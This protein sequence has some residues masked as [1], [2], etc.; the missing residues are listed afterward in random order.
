M[1]LRCMQISVSLS[2]HYIIN[3]EI[4]EI[5]PLKISLDSRYHNIEFWKQAFAV[6]SSISLTNYIFVTKLNLSVSI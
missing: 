1:L 6:E 5:F 4:R 3:E 2:Q